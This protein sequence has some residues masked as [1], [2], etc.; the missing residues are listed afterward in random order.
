[1]NVD[2]LYEE[3]LPYL[4]DPKTI[5]EFLDGHKENSIE[6][7]VVA[8]NDLM[9]KSDTPLKTDLR[10]LLNRMEKYRPR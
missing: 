10:I 1:M 3:V 8:V 2:D 7:L 6:G 5:K 9:A 4:S